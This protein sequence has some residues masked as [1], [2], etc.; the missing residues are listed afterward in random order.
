MSPNTCY[1]CI[2]SKHLHRRG[3]IFALIYN[4]TQVYNKTHYAI[5]HNSW[6]A[7]GKRRT[8]SLLLT[9]TAVYSINATLHSI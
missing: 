3:A 8:V 1:P 4:R 6:D 2:P 5:W 7:D 9:A